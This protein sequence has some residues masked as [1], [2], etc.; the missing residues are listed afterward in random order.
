DS[1]NIRRGNAARA[2]QFAHDLAD[3]SPPLLRVL[4]RPADMV[5]AQGDTPR[6]EGERLIGWADQDPDRRGGAD[7]EAK[8]AAHVLS[9]PRKRVPRSGGCPG[10]PRS[11]D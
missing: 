7:V 2:Q 9:Y 5:R 1:G 6:G 10:L 4:L 8:N 3:V 11:R